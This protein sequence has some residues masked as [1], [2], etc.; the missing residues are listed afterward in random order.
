MGFG[1]GCES[2]SK[3]CL[4]WRHILPACSAQTA[5]QDGHRMGSD[6]NLPLEILVSVASYRGVA[7]YLLDVGR[8]ALGRYWATSTSIFASSGIY[9]RFLAH[10]TFEPRVINYSETLYFIR[11]RDLP[12][13]LL[14]SLPNRDL[15]LCSPAPFI[16][17]LLH[18]EVMHA[19]KL[20]LLLWGREVPYRPGLRRPVRLCLSIRSSRGASSRVAHRIILG[21]LQKSA[22]LFHWERVRQT[23]EGAM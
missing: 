2:A 20:R 1:C 8:L 23:L 18:H 15:L 9:S 7:D 16:T 14:R 12:Q 10:Q 13:R 3:C 19:T 5:W 21:P 11:S 22:H 4:N 6:N 17:S